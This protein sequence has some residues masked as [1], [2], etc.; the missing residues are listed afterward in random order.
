MKIELTHASIR[1]LCKVLA[2]R[3]NEGPASDLG[4]ARRVYGIPRGGVPVAYMLEREFPLHFV[5]CETPV[6]ADILVD[7]I[8]DSGVTRQR[9]AEKFPTLPFYALIDKTNASGDARSEER[10]VGKECR[11]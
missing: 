11:L 2:V 9:W 4:R 8:I 3:I 10:R 1:D 7:D 5:T 6:D